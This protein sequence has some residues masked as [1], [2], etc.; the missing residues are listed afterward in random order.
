MKILLIVPFIG[1]VLAAPVV[2][3]ENSIKPIGKN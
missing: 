3:D 1:M 2:E